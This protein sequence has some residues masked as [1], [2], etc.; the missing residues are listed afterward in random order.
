MQRADWIPLRNISDN[1][2]IWA[3]TKVRI[4]NVGLNVSNKNHDYYEYLVSFIFDNDEHL[5]LTNLT[6][7]KAG[8]ILCV[9]KK[10]TPS[11]YSL[12]KT[13]KA[14]IGLEN[15]FVFFE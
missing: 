2:K 7:G 6:Q 9:V 8:N 14:M 12:G 3:G 5:Q 11:H 10:H 1:E 13:L 4:Y 15:T